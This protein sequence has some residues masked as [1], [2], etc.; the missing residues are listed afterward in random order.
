MER[1]ISKSLGCLL[2]SALF[3]VIS[4]TA[5]HINVRFLEET[6]N[7]DASP[8]NAQQHC[9]RWMKYFCFHAL[10][11]LCVFLCSN[12]IIFEVF[13]VALQDLRV[14]KFRDIFIWIIIWMLHGLEYMESDLVSLDSQFKLPSYT[15]ICAFPVAK[16]G[17][18]SMMRTESSSS[19]SKMTKSAGRM[20]LPTFSRTF[21]IIPRGCW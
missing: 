19:M 12:K 21:S 20:N 10:D 15:L 13:R 1:K 6:G 9:S 3:N 14:V 2:S 11:P 7:G 16:K 4:S 17:L 5:L 18:P 8:Y